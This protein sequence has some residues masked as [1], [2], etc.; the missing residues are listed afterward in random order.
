M[1]LNNLDVEQYGAWSDLSLSLR[2]GDVNVIYGPNEAGKTTLSRFVRGMLYGFP[3]ADRRGRPYPE[4]GSGQLRLRTGGSTHTIRR[5]DASSGFDRIVIADEHG[6]S[7]DA[8]WLDRSLGNVSREVYEAVFAID[9][10]ELQELA[11]LEEA[12]FADRIYGLSL[13]DQG[14]RLIDASSLSERARSVIITPGSQPAGRLI[15]LLKQERDLQSRRFVRTDSRTEYARLTAERDQIEAALERDRRRQGEIRSELSGHRFLDKVYRPWKQVRQYRDELNRL[16]SSAGVPDGGLRQLDALSKELETLTRDRDELK[17]RAA[18]LK[19]QADK[20]SGDAEIEK[21]GETIRLMVG[22]RGWVASTQEKRDAAAEDLKQARSSYDVARVGTPRQWGE[23]RLAALDNEALSLST[24]SEA[25]EAYTNSVTYLT[26]Y[27]RRYKRLR[28]RVGRREASLEQR[29]KS[30]GTTSPDEAVEATKQRIDALEA[31]ADLQRKENGVLLKTRTIRDQVEGLAAELEIPAWMYW[32]F[33]LFTAGGAFFVLMGLI[34]WISTQFVENGTTIFGFSTNVVVGLIYMLL[35]ITCGGLAFKMKLH[36]EEAVRKV[37]D[38]LYDDLR[39]EE[40]SQRELRMEIE[41]FF[42]TPQGRSLQ[43]L[44]DPSIDLGGLIRA[45]HRRLADLERLPE[46]QKRVTASRRKLAE[47]RARYRRIQQESDDERRTWCETLS[48][49]GIPETLESSE[50]FEHCRTI[51]AAAAALRN[52]TEAK[53]RHQSLDAT[54][55]SFGKELER[56][57]R[58]LHLWNVDR[59]RPV[60][61]LDRWAEQLTSSR[62]H[63]HRRQT[64]LD[65]YRRATDESADCEA[66]AKEVSRQRQVLLTKAGVATREEYEN[67]YRLAERRQ[68]AEEF[69]TIAEAELEAAASDEPQLAIVE[70]DL[71]RFD[72]KE[73]SEAIELLTM[74]LEDLSTKIE[75]ARERRGEIGRELETLTSADDRSEVDYELARVE[76][77]L[78]Q[79]AGDYLAANLAQRT[80]NSMRSE[81]ERNCQ[82][83]VLAAASDLLSQM[84]RG[85]YHQLRS[86]IGTK[87]ILVTD[88]RGEEWSLDCL[89]GGTR[90][91]IFLS[92]RLALVATLA[93]EGIELPV[94]IDDVFVNFD[95]ERTEAAAETIIEFARQGRQVLYFTC[96]LHLAHL[97]Q[98]RGVEPIWLPTRERTPAPRMAG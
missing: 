21:H 88:D 51:S 81:L 19:R 52:W 14:R 67:L 27:R 92:I 5:S 47:A 49:L 33:G 57:G 54:L 23:D 83:P 58:A 29:L 97:F 16:K 45:E 53:S 93:D 17:A 74:E 7:H 73:N 4:P 61:V 91:Q 65:E 70:E 35:G 44:D 89:S 34:A 71:E 36:Y 64:L 76:H 38:G 63:A 15:E 50:A 40:V 22:F 28:E 78:D 11:T 60:E 10:Y 96:H 13:G 94:L 85:R 37:T 68:E 48:S 77:Q 75:E 56:V 6:R 24:L 82:P 98:S 30:L 1:Q 8:G 31:L 26:S 12:D 20:L 32:V 95:Q 9:L 42:R 86:P 2:E 66:R 25:S 90:E 43:S 3:S 46:L 39:R 41:R 72:S 62:D 84:T 18:D 55:Q 59:T 87:D 79:V 80:F 69:L